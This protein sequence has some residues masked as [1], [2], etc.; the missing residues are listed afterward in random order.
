MRL[1]VLL[2]IQAFCIV[3][4]AYAGE[5][6]T[7]KTKD[8]FPPIFSQANDRP[9]KLIGTTSLNRE[10]AVRQR[11]LKASLI[12]DYI[13]MS[14]TC[15]FR[16]VE[17]AWL[18]IETKSKIVFSGE[19]KQGQVKIFSAGANDDLLLSIGAVKNLTIQCNDGQPLSN[20]YLNIIPDYMLNEYLDLASIKNL[21]LEAFYKNTL[22][23]LDK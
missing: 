4:Y 18:I 20:N 1:L 7:S 22:R 13:S 23:E 11:E 21:A 19:L 10:N 16:S 3:S 5:N 14:I 2:L 12:K 15:I 8:T 6:S 9:M 17:D